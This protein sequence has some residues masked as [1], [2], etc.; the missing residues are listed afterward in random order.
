MPRVITIE[1]NSDFSD[2]SI[3]FYDLEFA[4]EFNS[5][6]KSFLGRLIDKLTHKNNSVQYVTYQVDS[7]DYPVG[8]KC[9]SGNAFVLLLEDTKN[10]LASQSISVPYLK[11]KLGQGVKFYIQKS[12]LSITTSTR[13]EHKIVCCLSAKDSVT[14]HIM[15]REFIFIIKANIETPHPEISLDL[16]SQI[17]YNQIDERTSLGSFLVYYI[18]PSSN[19]CVPNIDISAIFT[20]KDKSGKVVPNAV[21]AKNDESWVTEIVNID[22]ICA[23]ERDC[24]GDELAVYEVMLYLNQTVLDKPISILTDYQLVVKG[25]YTLT[26]D[27]TLYRLGEIFEP[28]KLYKEI[29]KTKL[30]ITIEENGNVIHVDDKNCI[31]LTKRNFLPLSDMKTE[32]KVKFCNKA[33]EE[34]VQNAGL[35]LSNLTIH[36]DGLDELFIRDKDGHSVKSIIT[37]HGCNL[38]ALASKL[39]V[40][41]ADGSNLSECVTLVFVPSRINYITSGKYDFEVT[42]TIDIK[43]WENNEGLSHSMANDNWLHKTLTLV[44]HLYMMPHGEWLCLDY[45]SSAIV[46]KYGGILLDLKKQKE[47]LLQRDRVLQKY[48]TDEMENGTKFLNSDIIFMEPLETHPQGESSLCSEQNMELPYTSQAVFLSPTSS[49]IRDNEVTPVPCLKILIGNE[50]LPQ[51]IQ[52]RIFEYYHKDTDNQDRVVLST[53][54]EV[55]YADNCILRINTIM[56][57]SY[58]VLFKYFVQPAL[59]D[60][61]SINRLILTYPNTY[62]P[63]HR[64]VLG[65][66]AKRVFPQV[67][68][69]EFVCESDAVAAYYMRHWKEYHADVSKLKQP[70]GENVLV[71]DMGAGTLDLTFFSQKWN[72]DSCKHELEILGKIGTGKAGNYIDTVIA[73]IICRKLNIDS[74]ISSVQIKGDG[75]TYSQRTFLKHVIKQKIKPA[76]SNNTSQVI[77]FALQKTGGKTYAIDIIDILEDEAFIECLNDCTIRVIE[78]LRKYIGMKRPI[79]HTVIMSGRSCKLIPLQRRLEKAVRNCCRDG[80]EPEFITLDNP[81]NFQGEMIADRQKTVVVEGAEIMAKEIKH[82]ESNVKIKSHRLYATY[83]VIYVNVEGGKDYI[84]LL[85]HQ[86]SP[87]TDTESND[88]DSDVK[89][90]V[91]CPNSSIQLIQTYMSDYDTL[92]AFKAH[93]Y[94]YITLMESYS[95]E[96]FGIHL[97]LRVK[98]DELNNV[99]L[100]VNSCYSSGMPPKGMDLKNPINRKSLWPVVFG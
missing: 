88:F 28:F 55:K 41:I 20:L 33:S 81:I 86:D 8:V 34:I 69:L 3:E 62:T 52:Y 13:N 79:I 54:E 23:N 4:V 15:K 77:T 14:G 24:N 36:E 78:N 96:E 5:R 91:I 25:H 97:M 76:L 43:Y 53:A 46:C 83:G 2:N 66:I 64:G 26:N 51:D 59:V 18:K 65:Q 90:I 95:T 85:N 10:D 12:A 56:A 6:K 74:A 9:D 70:Q 61:A 89:K 80:I 100:M 60:S 63:Y 45:G 29:V 19:Y 98:I 72:A 50:F 31:H 17:A 16:E 42:S 48:V 39:G 30:D 22:D 44:W 37:P 1:I 92:R 99:T 11:A 38:C 71:Y 57:E 68:E 32:V 93:D 35:Y 84:E 7:V 27:D 75:D 47:K 21:Y 87:Y 82:P 73:E 58:H 49:L 40:V 94:E 67:R